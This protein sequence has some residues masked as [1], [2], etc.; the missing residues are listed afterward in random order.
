MNVGETTTAT[1]DA[2]GKIAWENLDQGDY[3]I[4]ETKT[5]D[6]CALLTDVIKV[7]LP[8]QLTKDEADSYGNVNKDLAKEDTNY[9][10]KWYFFD[11]KYEIKNNQVFL[12]PMTGSDG[13]WMYGFVGFAAIAF[14]GCLYLL[15]DEKK[16]NK[17]K[18]RRKRR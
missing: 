7:T 14:T 8:L 2:D 6:G 9:T 3:E 12:M 17:R 18:H 10:K 1:T 15:L 4:R 16:K 5:V 13:T 11:C